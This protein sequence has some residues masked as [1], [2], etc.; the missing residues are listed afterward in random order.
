MS[1]RTDIDEIIDSGFCP[2]SSSGGGSGWSES[3]CNL[4]DRDSERTGTEERDTN[5]CTLDDWIHCPLL[6]R[7]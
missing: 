7:F 6:R 1:I 2:Y 5:R 3:T 4:T